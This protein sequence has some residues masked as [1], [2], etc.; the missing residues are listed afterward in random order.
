M[1]T[2]AQTAPRV[3]QHRRR[4]TFAYID[5]RG[6]KPRIKGRRITVANVAIWHARQGESAERI[7]EDYHLSLAQVYSALA[8]YHD[9]RAAID[10]QIDS[11][12]ERYEAAIAHPSRLEQK[13]RA[14]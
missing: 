10:R 9:H 2:T 6:A 14:R 5:T 4:P 7:A 12:R 3:A 11:E 13:L 8:Y 1:V